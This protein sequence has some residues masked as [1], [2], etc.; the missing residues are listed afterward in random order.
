[1]SNKE[2]LAA[3]D[4]GSNSFHIVVVEI[5]PESQSFKV[6]DRLKETVRFESFNKVNHELSNTD[7]KKGFETLKRFKKLSEG[8]NVSEIF[9]SATSAVREAPNGK[10][11]LAQV[12]SGLF[13]LKTFFLIL[14]I[15]IKFV[16]NF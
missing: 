1:L 14:E 11:W 7:M 2:R 12:R 9:A 5:N 8:H 6:L 3:I 15:I 13:Y 10:E 4:I 16:L